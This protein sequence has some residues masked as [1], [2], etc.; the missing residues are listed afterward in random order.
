MSVSSQV[1]LRARATT[2][3][4]PATLTT[5]SSHHLAV[6]I[7]MLEHMS[8]QYFLLLRAPSYR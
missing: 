6:S 8:T 4:H 2:A 5:P 7:E 1:H 3:T